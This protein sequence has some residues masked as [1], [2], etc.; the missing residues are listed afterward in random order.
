MGDLFFFVRVMVITIVVVLLMQIRWGNTTIENH[1]MN[2][3]SSSSVVKPIDDV[4]SGTVRFI[5]NSWSAFIKGIN[6]N[7]SNALRRENQPG[8]RHSGFNLQ[9][10]EQ[11]V[12]EQAV[13]TRDVANDMVREHQ[14]E[15]QE[16]KNTA[17][18]Y[19]EK[20]KKKAAAASKNIRGQFVDE[21][22]VP[23][24]AHRASSTGDDDALNEE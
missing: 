17:T 4:A 6:T 12:R 21:T 9:R 22:I 16:A 2:F 7:F 8:Q 10:S 23:G 3:I 19:Y 14:P 20:F 1:A 15:I 13:K 24:D 5:R 11:Y 18:N